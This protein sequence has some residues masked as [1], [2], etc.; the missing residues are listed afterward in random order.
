MATR[1]RRQDLFSVELRPRLLEVN[2]SP[3]L[4]CEAPIDLKIKV[5][6]EKLQLLSSEL[7][8]Y[9]VVHLYRPYRFC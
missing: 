9:R 7:L 3:S 4:N 8:K 1:F 6:S 5:R 2:L